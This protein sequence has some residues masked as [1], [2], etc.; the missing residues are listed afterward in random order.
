MNSSLALLR[1]QA[2]R[3][4][5]GMLREVPSPCVSVCRMDMDTELCEGCRRTLDEIAAWGRMGE[6][7]KREVWAEIAKRLDSET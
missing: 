3:V 7:D 1:K 2:R 5:G 6:D 4:A